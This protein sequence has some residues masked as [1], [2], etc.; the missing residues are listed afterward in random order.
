MEIKCTKE[1]KE[2]II[3]AFSD[4]DSVYCPFTIC[5]QFGRDCD[6]CLRKTIK[7]IIVNTP[8][9]PI[10]DRKNKSVETVKTEFSGDDLNMIL[11][12]QKESEATSVKNAIMNA[13]SLALDH[14]DD[15]K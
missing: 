8:T 14:A 2:K 3:N 10:Y 1:E 6:D 15:C 12:Y 11:E 13:I 7:W 9:I 4:E 5:G